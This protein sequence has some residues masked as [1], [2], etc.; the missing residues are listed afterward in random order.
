M[1]ENKQGVSFKD[2]APQI[3]ILDASDPIV[4]RICTAEEMKEVWNKLYAWW[5][6]LE[7]TESHR[8]IGKMDRHSFDF[9]NFSWIRRIAKRCNDTQL[10]SLVITDVQKREYAREVNK[11]AKGLRQ[12]LRALGATISLSRFQE[13][14][15]QMRESG[16]RSHEF[17]KQHLGVL[18]CI[19]K[20]PTKLPYLHPKLPHV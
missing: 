2:W 1:K 18:I 5:K 17:M 13:L 14:E 15:I 6:E 4:Q 11:H 8:S 7:G 3:S 20:C 10:G 12:N 19:Q 9:Y 16:E